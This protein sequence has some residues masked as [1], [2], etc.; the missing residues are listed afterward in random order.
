MPS[1]RSKADSREINGIKR[2]KPS[3][4]QALTP[5]PADL[6]SQVPSNTVPTNALD[7]MSVPTKT[8]VE[9][10]MPSTLET[11]IDVPLHQS[12]RPKQEPTNLLYSS[13]LQKFG[14]EIRNTP[15]SDN[16]KKKRNWEGKKKH[17]E[18]VQLLLPSF[19][20]LSN[21]NTQ[22]HVNKKDLD[23]KEVMEKTWS[24]EILT[25]IKEHVTR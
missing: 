10:T 14:N 6:E 18:T 8:F 12:S 7:D 20:K 22:L 25:D 16:K 17:E 4:P 13:E 15:L 23:D 5:L 24:G 21:E 3:P 19:S 1:G 2:T 9:H 11:H